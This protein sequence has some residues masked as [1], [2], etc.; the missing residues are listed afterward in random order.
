MNKLYRKVEERDVQPGLAVCYHPII[1]T[2]KRCRLTT[3]TT[4]VHTIG[5]DSVVKVEGVHG[6]VFLEALELKTD[7]LQRTLKR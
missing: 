4:E 1:G 7:Y 6:C 3:I 2:D 5:K